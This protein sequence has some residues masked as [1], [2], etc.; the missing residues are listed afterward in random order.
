MYLKVNLFK[1]PIS[2]HWTNQCLKYHLEFKPNKI[3]C[4]RN[5][6]WFWVHYIE[7]VSSPISSVC[8]DAELPDRE[9][10]NCSQIELTLSSIASEGPI[11]F[12]DAL[13]KFCIIRF[14]QLTTTCSIF[15]LTNYN[16]SFSPLGN[17]EQRLSTHFNSFKFSLESV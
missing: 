9:M 11:Y 2:A 3:V 1:N 6:C 5:K 16:I 14:L 12:T 8:G 17:L 10:A 15:H 13:L 7:K 4:Q